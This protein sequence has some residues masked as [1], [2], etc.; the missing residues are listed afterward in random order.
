MSTSM[1]RRSSS[2]SGMVSSSCARM[3]K[4][5]CRVV[6]EWL[7]ART[8]LRVRSAPNSAVARS[9]SARA[10]RIDSSVDTS[11]SC[12]SFSSTSIGSAVKLPVSF[13]LMARAS[14]VIEAVCLVRLRREYAASPAPVATTAAAPPPSHAALE[15]DDP[16]DVLDASTSAIADP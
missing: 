10:L 4:A 14:A 6:V 13:G 16:D 1:A 3:P 7:S 8:K 2:D 12:E 15:P 11:S 5:R 9:S